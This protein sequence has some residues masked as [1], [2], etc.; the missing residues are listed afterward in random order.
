VPLADLQAA[1]QEVPWSFLMAFASLGLIFLLFRKRADVFGEVGFSGREVA[2]LTLGSIA[3]WS[4]NVPIAVYGGTYLAVN[5]GGVVVPLMLVGW[6]LY[7]R[8]LSVL[9]TIAGTAVVAL[10]ASRTVDFEPASGIVA[11]YPSFFLPVAVALVFALAVTARNPIRGAPLAYASGTLGALLGADLLHVRDMAAY[12]TGAPENTIVSIGGAGVFDMV[13]LAGAF[14]MAL[15]LVLIVLIRRAPAPAPEAPAYPGAPLTLRDSRKVHESFLRVQKPN[16]LERALAGLAVSNLA[17]REGAFDRSVRMSWLAVDSL[18]REPPVAAW[19][20]QE[21]GPPDGLRSDLALLR[22]RSDA[23]RGSASSLRDA[24][25]AN[26]TAKM[27][28]AAL[29]P[30]AGLAHA[31]EGVA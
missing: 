3:G 7:K 25:E 11:R 21:K 5:V 17:L 16:G 15:N 18:A 26:L 24:G 14:A 30:K 19:L 28:V 12:F 13:F 1:L 22:E 9:P 8:K 6:W 29:A 31:L 23:A 27:L 4:V 2:L 10:V 20:E